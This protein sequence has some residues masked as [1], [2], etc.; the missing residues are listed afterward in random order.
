MGNLNSYFK[1]LVNNDKFKHGA[2]AVLFLLVT[3]FVCVFIYSGADEKT[4]PVI[5]TTKE[6]TTTEMATTTTTTTEV[7]TTEAKVNIPLRMTATSLQNDLRIR[8]YDGSG[9]LIS[10][11]EFSIVLKSSDGKEKE[12]S[13]AEKRGI[14]NIGNLAAGAY[15][16]TLNVPEGFD[17]KTPSI[18]ATVKAKVEYKVVKEVKDEVKQANEVNEKKEDTPVKKTPTVVTL[19]DTVEFVPSTKTVTYE[20]VEVPFDSVVDPAIPEETTSSVDTTSSTETTTE[21]SSTTVSSLPENLHD[22]GGNILYIKNGDNYIEAT[23]ENYNEETHFYKK[24]T[25][26]SYTGWQFIDGSRYYYDKNGNAVTGEQVIQGAKYNFGKSGAL[27]KNSGTLGIDVSKYQGNIDWKKVKASG[28]NFVI[29]RCAYRGYGSGVLV[30]DSKFKANLAGARAAGL[31]VG[32]YIFSQATNE[33]EAVEE[34]SLCVS[35]LNGSHI[36]YPIYIDIENSGGYPNGRADNLNR[37]QRTAIAK[38]FCETVKNAGYKAG[39]YA[40][41]SFLTNKLDAAAISQYYIW[42]AHYVDKTNYA[43]VYDM[44]QYTSSGH[45]DGISG[46]VDMNL[47]YIY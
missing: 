38:A 2:I 34:A 20:Y 21:D 22:N 31:N 15:T 16:I 24:V 44:W 3:V 7:S 17:C 32:I 9:K 27:S 4:T 39:V 40:N 37:A 19:K 5:A 11:T 30:E 25:H 23:T 35:M 26:E 41:K 8:F 45:V 36:K 28:V 10:G 43:G 18:K 1:K 46:N 33:A 12:Y 29:I 42:L 47:G 13:D 14:I 6:E